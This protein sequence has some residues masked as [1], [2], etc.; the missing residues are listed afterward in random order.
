MVGACAI[1]A[2]S[3]VMPGCSRSGGSDEASSSA[4]GSAAAPASQA[5][6]AV[7]VR[8]DTVALENLDVV[9]TAPGRTEALRQDRVRAPFPARLVSLRVTDGDRVT[10]GE[11]V[12]QV[13]SKNSEA[14]LRG[15]QQ[16]LA[17]ARTAQ[18][19]ADAQRAVELAQ[20]G[21]VRQP[22]RAPT[23]GVVLSHGAETGD[24]VDEGEV[25][26]TIAEAGAVYFDAQVSQSDV[27]RIRPSQHA[28]IDMPAAG[29]VVTAVVHGVL[30][31]ASSENLSAPVRLD[32][33]PARPHLSVGLFGT[34]HIVVAQRRD[35]AV[36]PVASVLR[37]D[38]TGLSRVAEVR[39][40]GTAHWVV[41]QTGVQQ[42]GRVEILNPRLTP[43]TR[44]V[45]DGQV[46]LPEGATVQVEQGAPG[47]SSGGAGGAGV[48]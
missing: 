21:L 46:G 47:G 22:L 15:A 18:D 6:T 16:M 43:G 39:P 31:S 2:L 8:V 45:T 34:A 10:A 20:R 4:A 23:G 28:T 13:E 32:F 27:A 17:S 9:V 36:V 33:Q 3:L 19:S 5:P 30:P 35:A 44:V 7:P 29:G 24:Y 11:V 37:D 40:D 41:V 14:A 38:V 25:L 1:L 12:A 26:V 42:E 48:S